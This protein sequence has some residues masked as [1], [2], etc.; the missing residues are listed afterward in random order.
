ME[1]KESI[2]TLFET[3]KQEL[4]NAINE[5]GAVMVYDLFIMNIDGKEY[6]FKCKP[7]SAAVRKQVRKL[8]NKKP[9]NELQTKLLANDHI[10]RAVANGNIDE[11]SLS[12]ALMASGATADDIKE[13]VSMQLAN[14]EAEEVYI[15]KLFK[16]I[17]DIPEELKEKF[18]ADPAKE[19]SIY[20]QLDIEQMRAVVNSFR[21]GIA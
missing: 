14:E 3:N 9:V 12:A 8:Q 18:S 17:V 19:T 7:R 6:K 16:E 2:K 20:W 5:S 15:M 4:I 10:K 21:S 13:I 1:L 11:K